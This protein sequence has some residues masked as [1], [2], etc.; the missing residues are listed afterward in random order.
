MGLMTAALISVNWGIYVWAI[1]SGHALDAALGYYIN[2]LF[3][4][5]LGAVLLGE[6]L[7]R[8]AVA[9]DRA[10]HGRRG[11]PDMGGRAVAGGGV[12]PDAD[13]GIYAYLKRRL[14]IGPNQGF[15]LEVLILSAVRIGYY[16]V[17]GCHGSPRISL[18][19]NA[20]ETCCWWAAGS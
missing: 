1:G 16:R 7:T 13:L 20:H 17:A 4:V 15:A 12:G 8:G 18:G 5:L 19:G 11:D 10:G 14:P 3:S 9:G 6:R 2:P